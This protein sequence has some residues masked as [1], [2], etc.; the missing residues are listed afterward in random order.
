RRLPQRVAG[1]LAVRDVEQR[2]EPRVAPASRQ[3]GRA[4]GAVVERVAGAA[5]DAGELLAHTSEARDPLVDLVELLRDARANRL[6][7][8][9]GA[10]E[11][12][13][14]GDLLECEAEPL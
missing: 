9:A 12:P 10:G 3:K 4:A 6:V 5:H 13:V 7:R 1:A 14:L 2:P 8:P 11:P